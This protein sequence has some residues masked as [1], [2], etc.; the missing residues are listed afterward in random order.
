MDERD[1]ESRKDKMS[2]YRDQKGLTHSF[3]PD[4]FV[5]DEGGFYEARC[6]CGLTETRIPD[7][8]TCADILLEHVLSIQSYEWEETNGD[9]V[10]LLLDQP[11]R[12]ATVGIITQEA[13]RLDRFRVLRVTNP[14]TGALHLSLAK[15]ETSNPQI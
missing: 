12:E 11:G 6:T 10:M 9:L 1:Y 4:S 2:R 5:P 8:A 14:T 7:A 13:A 3:D 15:V